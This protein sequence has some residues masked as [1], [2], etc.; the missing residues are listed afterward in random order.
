M[1][2]GVGEREPADVRDEGPSASD[3]GLERRRVPVVELVEQRLVADEREDAF[4]QVPHVLGVDRRIELVVA[5]LET[6]LAS[7]QAP[8]AVERLDEGAQALM[9]RTELLRDRVRIGDDLADRDLVV[10]HADL[11]DRSLDAA[12]CRRVAPIGPAAGAEVPAAHI[13]TVRPCVR[14]AIGCVLFVRGRV[15]RRVGRCGRRTGKRDVGDL[16]VRHEQRG[17]DRRDDDRECHPRHGEP[18]VRDPATSTAL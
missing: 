1:A 18:V 17:R 13:G 8:A 15:L 11:V 9:G 7:A 16:V 10:G 6:E 3:V 12:R 2:A 5:V 4:R 14:S